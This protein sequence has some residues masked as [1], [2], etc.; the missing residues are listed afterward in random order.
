MEHKIENPFEW[1]GQ[2]NEAL[3]ATESSKDGEKELCIVSVIRQ[4]RPE[5]FYRVKERGKEEVDFEKWLEA[6]DHY[7]SI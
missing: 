3:L 7:N 4:E 1:E 6:V 5:A 2:E